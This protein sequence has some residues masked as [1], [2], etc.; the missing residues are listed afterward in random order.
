[1][2]REW[3]PWRV[4]ENFSVAGNCVPEISLES[5]CV[6]FSEE[7]CGFYTLIV[8]K[9]VICSISFGKEGHCVIFY[10][11]LFALNIQDTLL[12][13]QKHCLLLP[14]L[15]SRGNVP[16]KSI[17]I[18]RDCVRI[19]SAKAPQNGS[20]QTDQYRRFS[21]FNHQLPCSA[22][23]LEDAM[24]HEHVVLE[25]SKGIFYSSFR[26]QIMQGG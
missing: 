14:C 3:P 9:L 21:H 17:S 13:S 15:R 8:V 16:W 10:L 12:I 24:L 20:S 18:L 2:R 11:P 7:I 22:H 26:M 1:M 23:T 6:L 25:E 5:L 4:F 19:P